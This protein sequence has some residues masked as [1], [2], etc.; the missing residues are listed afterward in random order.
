MAKNFTS[1]GWID[2]IGKTG[3]LDTPE[4][5][6]LTFKILDEIRRQ[7]TNLDTKVIY[8]QRVRFED[9]HIELRLCYYMKRENWIFGRFAA[10]LPESDFKAIT[11]EAILRGWI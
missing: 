2:N 10:L 4:K 7:Q 1:E 5:G 11:D 9:G 6:I 3:S 8:L